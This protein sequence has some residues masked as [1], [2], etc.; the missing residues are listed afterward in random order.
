MMGDLCPGAAFH[1]EGNLDAETTGKTVLFG[2]RS[3]LGARLIVA[4]ISSRIVDARGSYAKYS[5]VIRTA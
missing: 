1:D 4:E 5:E 3:E 2:M